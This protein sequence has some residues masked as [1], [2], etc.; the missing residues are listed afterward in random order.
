M[1]SM[2][3]P[4]AE[5]CILS[6]GVLLVPAGVLHRLP[7]LRLPQWTSPGPTPSLLWL[8]SPPSPGQPSLPPPPPGGSMWPGQ[9]GHHQRAAPQDGE[10][11]G[12]GRLHLRHIQGLPVKHPSCRACATLSDSTT[13]GGRLAQPPPWTPVVS[14]HLGSLAV[15]DLVVDS[16]LHL[17]RPRRRD[18]LGRGRGGVGG[19][20]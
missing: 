14:R 9:G 5:H 18:P 3:D 2:I 8:P 15:V 11:G 4:S 12:R 16:C 10:Q 7:Y 17:P 13:P 1:D 6:A 19:V 20:P